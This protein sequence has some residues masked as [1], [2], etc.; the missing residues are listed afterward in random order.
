MDENLKEEILRNCI[1]KREGKIDLTWQ[2]LA[3]QYKDY[4]ENS[5]SIRCWTKNELKKQG[6]LPTKENKIS[7]DIKLK[8]DKIQ[9]KEIEFEKEKIRF[10]DQKREYRNLI[11]IEARWEHLQEE[12][13]KSINKLNIDKPLLNKSH[14]DFKSSNDTE[15]SLCLSDWHTGLETDNY[16][17]KYN[18]DIEK[19]RVGRLTQKV[20]RYC[21]NN[22]VKILHVEL[23]GDMI[24]GLIHL[25]TRVSNEEDVINQTMICAEILSEML[26]DLSNVV[27]QINVYS[28]YGNHSRVTA[29]IKDSLNMENFE[30]LIPWYLKTRLKN[31][32]NIHIIDNQFDEELIAYKVHGEYIFGLHGHHDKPNSV[33]DNWSK[34]LK[35]FPR[36]VH[37]GHLHKHYESEDYDILVSVNGSLCGV[38]EFS[39]QIRKTNSPFQK[40]I[41]Y[42]VN[43]EDSYTYRIRV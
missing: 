41:I 22:K 36:E 7:K 19:Q 38:E 1:R 34:M 3:C 16:F 28:T 17:N 30:R 33:V 29:S 20:K 4:F 26:T 25:S 21:I 11:R 37:L 15:A 32:P 13:I 6:K 18:I 14:L 31:F 12:M 9:L 23:L 35:I 27:E 43:D 2:Q 39:K 5:E 10:Q 40:L 24:N 8:L 42:K